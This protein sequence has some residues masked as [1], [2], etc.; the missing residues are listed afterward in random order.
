MYGGLARGLPYRSGAKA[1]VPDSELESGHWMYHIAVFKM[2]LI[3][4]FQALQE[5]C[6][7][8]HTTL[9]CSHSPSIV[10]PALGGGRAP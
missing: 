2:T 7:I 10:A 4:G 3:T 8:V 5:S 6:V 9:E 1:P